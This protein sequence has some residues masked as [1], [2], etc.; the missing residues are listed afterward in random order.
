MTSPRRHPLILVSMQKGPDGTTIAKGSYGKR[1]LPVTPPSTIPP[2]M[3]F[4]PLDANHTDGKGR[5]VTIQEVSIQEDPRDLQLINLEDQKEM[6]RA[7][8]EMQRQQHK[9]QLMDEMAANEAMSA[10]NNALHLELMD[11]LRANL[12][13]ALKANREQ[14]MN[15]SML[16]SAVEKIVERRIKMI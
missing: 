14:S 12:E 15:N 9:A 6:Q 4:D 11:S 8:L 7:A 2:L 1:N 3:I 5:K 13:H 16:A 10:A